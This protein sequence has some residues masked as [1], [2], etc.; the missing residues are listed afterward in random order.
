MSKKRPDRPLYKPKGRDTN[1][2]RAE[3]KF[4]PRESERDVAL[5]KRSERNL[6][7]QQQAFVRLQE[8]EEMR[9][10][11]SAAWKEKNAEAKLI[12]KEE[13]RVVLSLSL[14]L[15]L[16]NNKSP[17]TNKKTTKFKK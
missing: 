15:S 6:K 8:L 13:I 4:K 16:Q 9:R 12:A 11:A 10:K 5:K 3:K 17:K 7:T 14:S 2:R 1:A